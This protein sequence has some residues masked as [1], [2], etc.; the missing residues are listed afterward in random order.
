MAIGDYDNDLDMIRFAGLGVAM[1]NGSE[2][3]KAGADVVTLS[4]EEDGVAV[5]IER[6]VLEETSEQGNR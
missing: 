1:A 5:A 2:A 6:Y 4:N 3:A